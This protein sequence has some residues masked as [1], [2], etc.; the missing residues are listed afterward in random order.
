SSMESLGACGCLGLGRAAGAGNSAR[1]STRP[2]DTWMTGAAAGES[3]AGIRDRAP[4]PESTGGNDAADSL[5]VRLTAVG[6]TS[7]TPVAGGRPFRGTTD[8]DS[9]A[10]HCDCL[11]A[12]AGIHSM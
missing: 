11:G 7:W 4:A 8:A 6:I 10:S 2:I 9:A 12:I 1:T 5:P 3:V